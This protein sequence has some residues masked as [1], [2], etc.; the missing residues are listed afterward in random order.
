MSKFWYVIYCVL[1]NL[2]CILQANAQEV[3][4][5]IRVSLLTCG[6]GDELY[7][8]YGHS[9]LHVVDSA[10]NVDV[11]F[12]YGTFDFDTPNFYGKFLNGTL[13][14]M[15]SACDYSRFLRAYQRERREVREAE[16]ILSSPVKAEIEHLLIE[17]IRPENRF[18]RYDFFFDNCATRIRDI[19]FKA[20]AVSAEPY[21]EEIDGS[22]FRDCL[23]E[24]VGPNDWSGFGID[25]I[26]GVRADKKVSAFDKAMLPDYLESLMIDAGAIAAPVVILNR[27]EAVLHDESVVDAMTSPLALSLFLLSIVVV[28]SL[29]E[30]RTQR[31]F[32][33]IDIFLTV[34]MT[35]LALLFWYLWVVSEIKITSY[36][37]NVMWASV[38]YV[39]MAVT[40]LRG[41]L[42]NLKVLTK[43][44]LAIMVAY[45]LCVIF[46]VQ[47]AS[48]PIL[49]IVLTLIIRNVALLRK[50]A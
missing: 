25:L 10:L 22:T 45:L 27:P 35:L 50:C 49:I 26:L 9:A 12:N 46:G 17:N 8:A 43:V 32:K 1:V 11:V 24:K 5:N 38:L 6:P 7:T 18:Y 20:S 42:S 47:Y 23:H 19:V 48:S 21:R 39:P 30:V 4:Y 40:M 36:N 41:R 16:L 29:V 15:L 34:V 37:L 44:N 28:V 14:Y 31:W 2:L 33:G 3:N 13:D